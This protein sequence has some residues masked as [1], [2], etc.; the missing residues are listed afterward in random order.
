[1]EKKVDRLLELT[2]AGRFHWTTSGFDGA[3]SSIAYVPE[4]EQKGGFEKEVGFD[5]VVDVPVGKKM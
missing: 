3:T 5:D 2:V 1:M 4:Y